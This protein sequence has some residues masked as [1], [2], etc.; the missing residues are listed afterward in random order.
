MAALY[1]GNFRLAQVVQSGLVVHRRRTTAISQKF[2]NRPVI[3]QQSPGGMAS[4][5]GDRFRRPGDGC[6]IFRE[7]AYCD[8]FQPSFCS[9]LVPVPHCRL[10]SFGS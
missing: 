5:K 4:V 1:F 3:G 7:C 8:P 2:G 9:W 10:V 6:A